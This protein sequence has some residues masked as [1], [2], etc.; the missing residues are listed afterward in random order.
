MF[1][2]V[3]LDNY[4][5]LLEALVA[6]ARPPGARL[7]YWNML[8][9]RRRPESMAARLTPLDDARR[10][11]ARARPRVLLQRVRRSRRSRDRRCSHAAASVGGGGGLPRRVSRCFSAAVMRAPPAVVAASG[12][13]PQSAPCRLRAA[14]AVVSVSVPRAVAGPAADRR[15]R[16]RSSPSLKF[17]PA[18]RR[19]FGRVVDD[20]ERTTLGELY[21]PMA[22]AV[23]FWLA[24]GQSPLLFC[25]PMLVLT[26]ADATG[27]LIGLR[28]GLT[29][30]H[31]RPQ[32]VRR[33][34]GVR[35]G[36]VPLR[37]CAA[38]AVERYRA[39]RNALIAGDAGAAGDAARRHGVARARQSVSADRR[40][41]SA[42]RVS[43]DDRGGTAAAAARHGRPGRSPC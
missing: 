16:R 42:A 1:E 12:D 25:V 30:Y 23:V 11:P 28:Y 32:V 15:Q 36:R 2:Y 19:R 10:A 4:H 26:L 17:L 21:F 14:D 41:L 39:R 5:R 13:H 20:V 37:P 7:A 6:A 33:V 22:V 9:P 18:A 24:R 3:S 43:A 35:R 8:A 38:A 40:I 34:A 29:R 31:G 27:A